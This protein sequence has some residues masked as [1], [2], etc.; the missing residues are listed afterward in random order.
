MTKVRSCWMHGREEKEDDA[1]D[2]ENDDEEDRRKKKTDWKTG[3]CRSIF[4]SRTL[5]EC[6]AIRS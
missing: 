3:E 6:C 4:L 5:G 2:E 1:E